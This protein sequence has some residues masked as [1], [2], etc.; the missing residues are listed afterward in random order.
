MADDY[1]ADVY[2]I[3]TVG[4]APTSGIIEI[5]ADEDV[6]LVNLTAGVTYTFTITRAATAGL[7]DPYLALYS[8]T[9]TLLSFNDDV[10]PPTNTNAE[11]SFTAQVSGNHQLSVSNADV[12]AGTG[13][14]LVSAVI[15][16]QPGLLAGTRFADTLTGGAI[17]NTLLGYEGNDT[18][19]GKAG[20]DSL[21]G[22]LGNDTLVGGLGADVM[23]GG[24][25][26]DTYWVDQLADQVVELAGAGTDTVNVQITAAGTV[27]VLAAE[28]EHAVIR[29]AAAIHLTGNTLANALT[30]NAAANI[31]D[32]LGG[33]DTLSG[34]GGIDILS[35][36]LGA[37]TLNGGTGA[38]TLTGG[39]GNDLY[40][41]DDVLDEII[42]LATAGQGVDSVRATLLAGSTYTL[43]ANVEN[44][45]LLGTTAAHL[46]GNAGNN[47]ITG[48]AGANTLIGAGGADTLN[49]GAG[50]DRLEGGAGVDI[51]RFT[52]NVIAGNRDT[53]V[54]FS[55]V[56]DTL[57]LE[58]AVF[59]K[60]G[61]PGVLNAQFFAANATG[62][63]QD[64]NDYILYRTSDGALFYDSD[65]SGVVVKIQFATLLN[66]PVISAADIQVI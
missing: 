21:V 3:V 52:V 64:T 48:N 39:A 34:A 43:A 55:A 50:L 29:S 32:G 58:N 30:G 40:F 8:P 60:L 66:A 53:V 10:A 37:D 27:Y 31:L 1:P 51:F 65:G 62:V 61:A 38:D 9:G 2:G 42:E 7:A 47:V 26:N 56:D 5:A 24:L 11:L 6:F 49:G 15:A 14:Y 41:V 13:A 46:T 28:I 23:L 44:A 12:N 17:A 18:L 22:G 4:G 45:S 16:A 25:G 54:D 59:T 35:G 36:G 57:Q 63:A 20:N 19:D 33:N